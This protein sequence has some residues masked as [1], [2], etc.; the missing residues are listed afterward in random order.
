M[1]AVI[2]VDSQ[3]GNTARV[4]DAIR[5]GLGP[6][7]SVTRMGSPGASMPR[8]GTAE[9][10]VVGGPT[11]DHG[12][13]PSLGK[14]L[15]VL[16]SQVRGRSVVVFDTRYGGPALFTGSAAKGAAGRLRSAGARLLASPESFRVQ[17]APQLRGAPRSPA[18]VQL[19]RGEI[20]RARAWGAS[21]RD[22]VVRGR[23][24]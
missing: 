9:L 8:L 17:R 13:S 2:L 6:G 21:L 24:V 19:G 12:M 1:H 3:F 16:A 11:I 18:D 22:I 4:A 10:I 5:A 20:D 23:V 15:D 7:A 14:L